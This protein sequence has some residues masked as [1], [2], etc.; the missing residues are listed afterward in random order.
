MMNSWDRLSKQADQPYIIAEIAAN[1]NGDMTL[2]K[3]L[4]ESAKE[5]G[6]DCVKFQSWTK[7]SL[8]IKSTYDQELERT[9]DQ[10][11]MTEEKLWAMKKDCDQIGIDFACTPFS[12]S[13]VDLLVRI[14]VP[15]IKLSSTEITNIP[16]LQHAGKTGLPLVIS[17][18]MG[19]GAEIQEA[20]RAV[21]ETGN[22]RIVLLHCVSLYPPKDEQMNINNIDWLCER[23]GY[24]TGFSDHTIGTA[25]PLAA[26]AKGACVIEKHFTLDRSLPG[27]D[28][29]VSATPEEMKQI[30]EDSRRIRAALGNYERELSE[31]ERDSRRLFRRSVVAA[32]EITAGKVIEI[33]DLDAKRPGTGLSPSRMKQIVGKTALRTIGC[34]ELLSEEDF[35]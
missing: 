11:S 30:V 29:K 9:L 14:G 18:G 12:H 3:Q 16:L 1:H 35:G 13:E 21:E 2:A 34:D 26:V 27:W 33:N 8:M 22:R 31:E 24:P 19:T 7:T 20:I 5:A 4:I 10:Y 17:T 25:I 23:F 6:C 15:F 32:R 28:H